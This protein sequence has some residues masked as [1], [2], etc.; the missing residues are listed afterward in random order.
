[1][2]TSPVEVAPL[3]KVEVR[4]MSAEPTAAAKSEAAGFEKFRT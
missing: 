2:E 4:E 3:A 1:M